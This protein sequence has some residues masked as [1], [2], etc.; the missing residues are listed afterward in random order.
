MGRR[1]AHKA[2]CDKRAAVVERLSAG[3]RAS[4]THKKKMDMGMHMHMS[5]GMG[6]CVWT[7]T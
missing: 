4:T 5:T 1:Q 2:E 7:W 6:M 3:V